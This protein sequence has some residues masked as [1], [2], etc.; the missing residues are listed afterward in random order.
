MKLRY[1][2]FVA[3]IFISQATL[4]SNLLIKIKQMS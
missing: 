1:I 4:A 2:I 3:F